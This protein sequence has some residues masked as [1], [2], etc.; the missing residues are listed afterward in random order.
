MT[1]LNRA[2]HLLQ[3]TEAKLRELVSDAATSG[4]YASVVQ[5]AS[6]ARTLSELPNAKSTEKVSK[7]VRVPSHPQNGAKGPKQI[8]LS[9]RGQRSYPLFF[10][11]GDHVVRIAWSKSEK[12]EYQ[13]KTAYAVL[14]L[15][16]KS[17]AEKGADGRVFAT[18]QFLPIR[19]IQNSEVPNYQ[20]YVGI[21]L[22]KQAGLIDQ[23]GRQGY[24]IPRLGD[25]KDAVEAIWKKLPELQDN[26]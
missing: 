5:I 24:S 20:A 26:K 11:Q 7:I 13:H 10:R 14:K 23:H 8:S 2:S 21:A 17:M 4:D 18:E 9:K 19:D 22:F 15:L 12:K 6:W 25:F 1:I 16:A 3:E